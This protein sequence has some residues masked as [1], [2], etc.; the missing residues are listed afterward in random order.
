MGIAW[1]VQDLPR[2]RWGA[3]GPDGAVLREAQSSREREK[4]AAG[5]MGGQGGIPPGLGFEGAEP[6]ASPNV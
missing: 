2:G 3:R 5:V 1:L 6:L 4:G